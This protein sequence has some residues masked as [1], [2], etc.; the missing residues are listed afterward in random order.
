MHVDNIGAIFIL[1]NTEVYQW[2][3]HI[4]VCHHFIWYYVDG[5]TV[6]KFYSEENITDPFTKKLS[7]G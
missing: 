5:G 2:K 7:N 1:Q 4:D 3:N 6:K